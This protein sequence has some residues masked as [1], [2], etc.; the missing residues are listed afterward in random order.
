MLLV[1]FQ[2]HMQKAAAIYMVFE[3]DSED[4]GA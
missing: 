1:K 2:I 3:P 4:K